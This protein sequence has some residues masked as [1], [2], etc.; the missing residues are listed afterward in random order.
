M[1][2]D[3]GLLDHRLFG[4]R[5]SAKGLRPRR[6]A[7][8]T[9]SDFDQPMGSGQQADEGV[10]ELVNWRM[11][12]A[13]LPDLHRGADRAKQIELTHCHSNGCQ[14]RSRAKMVRCRCD[15]LVQGAAPPNESFFVSSLAR[16]HRP[17]FG[18]L[19]KGWQTCRYFG[20]NLGS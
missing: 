19:F 12:D 5:T 1:Q 20:R 18:K 9:G 17:A 14:A 15:R 11:L 13:F 3:I 6:I 2:A 10:I 4:T 8:Q 16:E 7:S